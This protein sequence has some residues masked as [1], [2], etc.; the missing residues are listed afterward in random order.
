MDKKSNLI[1]VSSLIF[2]T[3][4]DLTRYFI[5]DKKERVDIS[6]KVFNIDCLFKQHVTEWA[7]PQQHTATVLTQMKEWLD[8]NSD[9]KVSPLSIFLTIILFFL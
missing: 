4:S 5:T 1:K 8:Q 3:K 2:A 6:H 9:V 7:I